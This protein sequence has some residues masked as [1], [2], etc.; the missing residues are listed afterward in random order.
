MNP[1]GR[2]LPSLTLLV[3]TIV[4]ALLHTGCQSVEDAFSPAIIGP[5]HAPANFHLAGRKLP[6]AIR[7]VAVLPTT[8]APGNAAAKAGLE[9]VEP[10]LLD[11]FPKAAHFEIVRITREKLEALTGKPQLRADEKLP[12][13][14][15]EKLREESGCQA[16]LF[17][18]LT[19]YRAYPP[20][21]V[22][23]KLALFS[24]EDGQALWNLDELFDAGVPAIANSARRH[25]LQHQAT[26]S[27]LL[28][29]GPILN[30]PAS[31]TR[32]T[33]AAMAETIRPQGV[34]NK[35]K[36]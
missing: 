27:P 31:F 17:S 3:I 5:F 24:L 4:P 15:L 20:L 30:S 7:R 23:W 34:A 13:D 32:Y 33:V 29:E 28:R 6:D 14:L 1:I 22:G 16:V 35:A 26:A 25:L 21:G 19:V 36:K 12:P 9:T 8:S 18:E 2:I 10:L 11:E